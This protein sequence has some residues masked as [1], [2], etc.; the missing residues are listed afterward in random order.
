M[1]LD[2]VEAL[3]HKPVN[4]IVQ[5]RLEI[6]QDAY[7]GLG[8]LGDIA[9]NSSPEYDRQSEEANVAF[10]AVRKA[11]CELTIVHNVDLDRL[12]K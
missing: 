12:K 4:P 6:I 1:E 11:L 7:K 3:G 8:V 2:S 10:T 5:E 9:L